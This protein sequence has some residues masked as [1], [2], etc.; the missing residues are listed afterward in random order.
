MIPLLLK[1]KRSEN[2]SYPRSFDFIIIII[3]ISFY[4]HTV[5]V[6]YLYCVG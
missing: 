2:L 3:I 1:R 4:A 5:F 6:S